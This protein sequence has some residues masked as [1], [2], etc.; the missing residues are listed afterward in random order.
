MRMLSI[1]LLSVLAAAAEISLAVPALAETAE[2]G[3]STMTAIS[4]YI[5]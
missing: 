2:T 1:F 5:R 3:A 4:T